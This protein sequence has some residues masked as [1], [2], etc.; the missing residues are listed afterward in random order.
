MENV[1]VALAWARYCAV[2]IT[3]RLMSIRV[4]VSMRISAITIGSTDLGAVRKPIQ[5]CLAYPMRSDQIPKNGSDSQVIS[6]L[7][8]DPT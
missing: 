3:S 8:I 1:V 6:E 7:V 4:S 5:Y 2:E